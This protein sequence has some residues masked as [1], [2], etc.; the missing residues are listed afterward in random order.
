MEVRNDFSINSLLGDVDYRQ[1]DLPYLN[2]AKFVNKIT[3]RFSDNELSGNLD[4]LLQE[5]AEFFKLK[6]RLD[7]VHEPE[8]LISANNELK[9][10]VLRMSLLHD[11]NLSSAD[12]SFLDQSVEGNR[13][14]TDLLT[15]LKTYC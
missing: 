5:V 6:E 15:D 1:D 4:V 2:F 11:N 9:L 14:F 8:E 3:H 7:F 13:N 10:Q 12:K